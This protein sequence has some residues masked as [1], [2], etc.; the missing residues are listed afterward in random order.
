MIKGMTKHSV[1]GLYYCEKNKKSSCKESSS[2]PRVFEMLMLQCGEP[3]SPFLFVM[4]IQL[5]GYIIE[6]VIIGYEFEVYFSANIVEESSYIVFISQLVR[7]NSFLNQ[8]LCISRRVYQSVHET[9]V[10]SDISAT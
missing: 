8:M 7:Y 1:G 2:F 10:R 6:I 3:T 9:G 4:L 5:L